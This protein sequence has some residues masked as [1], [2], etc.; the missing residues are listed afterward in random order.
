MAGLGHRTLLAPVPGG[1]LCR[2][3]A[4]KLPEVSGGSASAAVPDCGHQ[5]DGDG[6]VHATQSLQG[7]EGALDALTGA[8]GVEQ[9]WP[10]GAR[11]LAARW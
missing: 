10:R 6:A 8:Y 11:H 9:T 1:V 4:Q 3:Q 7:R 2:E 5:S